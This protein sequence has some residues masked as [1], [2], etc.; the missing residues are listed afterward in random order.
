MHQP[1]WLARCDAL[2]YQPSLPRVA[3][4]S[5]TCVPQCVQGTMTTGGGVD[6]FF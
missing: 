3:S 2:Q 6:V 1:S 4:L 5:G